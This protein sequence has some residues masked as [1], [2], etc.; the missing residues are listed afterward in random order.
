MVM[1]SDAES[2]ANLYC[3]TAANNVAA[4]WITPDDSHVNQS[5]T[6]YNI[7]LSDEYSTFQYIMMS[8]NNSSMYIEGLYQCVIHDENQEYQILY[9]WI[10][11]EEFEGNERMPNYSMF[12]LV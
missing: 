2:F 6:I 3:L 12:S 5:T 9:V 10:Y 7:E 4:Y 11:P 8:V 1:T